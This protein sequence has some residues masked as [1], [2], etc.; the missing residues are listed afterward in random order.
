MKNS[1]G[2][3]VESL[4]KSMENASEKSKESIKTL[5]DSSSKHFES[6]FEKNM[7]VFNTVSKTLTEKEMDPSIVNTLK[8]DFGR[9]IKLSDHFVDAII[10]YQTKGIDLS[11]EFASEIMGILTGE[12]INT[13][14]GVERMVDILHN[15]LEKSTELSIKNMEKMIALYNEHLNLALNFNKVFADNINSQLS[16]LFKVQKKNMTDLFGLNMMNEW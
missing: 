2:H 12:D 8:S 11:I 3:H 7:K 5:I 13:L 6:A 10:D 16:I 1:N 15:N 4:K 9:S 14:K